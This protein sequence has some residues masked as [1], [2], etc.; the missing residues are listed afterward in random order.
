[1]QADMINPILPG[2]GVSLFVGLPARLELQL[3]TT[4]QFK[5]GNL[6]VRYAPRLSVD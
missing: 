3:T 4:R 2:A 5:N 1:M 6:L